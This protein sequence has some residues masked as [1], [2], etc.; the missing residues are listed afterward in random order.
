MNEVNTQEQNTQKESSD[1][2]DNRKV[3]TRENVFDYWLAEIDSKLENDSNKIQSQEPQY[4]DNYWLIPANNKRG[5][6][7]YSFKV[8]N[9]EQLN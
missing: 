5:A 8:Y 4:K 3:V 7:S 6:G 1:T 2:S 9:D